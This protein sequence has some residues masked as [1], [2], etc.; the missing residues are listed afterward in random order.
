MMLERKNVMVPRT[1]VLGVVWAL[2]FAGVAV[3]HIIPPEALHPVAEAY[4]RCTF[5][6]NLNPVPWELVRHDAETIEHWLRKVDPKAAERFDERYEEA[7][8]GEQR[9]EGSVSDSSPTRESKR[10]AVFELCTRAVGRTLVASLEEAMRVAPDRERAAQ[11]LSE[12]QS[13]FDA[14]G[15]TLPYLDPDGYRESGEAFLSASHAMGT[16]GLMGHGQAPFD[17]STFRSKLETI[18]VYINANFGDGFAAGGERR[19]VA[20]P[21]ASST[22]RPG[23]R[24]PPRLPPGANI[25]KQ[26]PRPRQILNMAVRG[27]DESETPLIALGDMA[28]DSPYIFGEPMRSLGMSCNTCHNKGVTNPNFT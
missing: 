16:A 26:I 2:S 13:V 12:A 1:I 8:D 23:A 28:F 19:L 5:V 11:R 24:I 20:R 6:L 18:T 4:R 14:F 17:S 10:R 21:L 7:L 22:Y 27:V 15:D 3:G 9:G 25:N